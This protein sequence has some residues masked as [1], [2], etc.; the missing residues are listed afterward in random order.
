MSLTSPSEEGAI[1]QDKPPGQ[2]TRESVLAAPAA[3]A[4]SPAAKRSG[5]QLG[6]IT[7]SAWVSSGLKMVDLFRYY[8][9]VADW[10][11]PHLKNRAVMQFG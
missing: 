7:R 5:V 6:S 2:I 9:S 11:L 1:A 8:E 10:I 3:V 4:A